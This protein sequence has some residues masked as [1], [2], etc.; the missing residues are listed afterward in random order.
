MWPRLL[1]RRR[2]PAKCTGAR[3][4]ARFARS[5]QA[6]QA[7]QADAGQ[8]GHPATPGMWRYPLIVPGFG[9]MGSVTTR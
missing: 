5:T 3:Y 7:N 2:H 6:N 9:R 8:P 1:M 4:L